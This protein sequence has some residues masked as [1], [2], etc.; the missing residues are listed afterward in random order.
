MSVI[1][2]LFVYPFSDQNTE[3]GIILADHMPT[4]IVY[5]K[6]DLVS[7]S[8]ITNFGGAGS[9]IISNKKKVIL[10]PVLRKE[11]QSIGDLIPTKRYYHFS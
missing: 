6:P 8:A 3:E 4:D 11:R 9:S 5:Y 7:R 10:T 2:C 1:Y